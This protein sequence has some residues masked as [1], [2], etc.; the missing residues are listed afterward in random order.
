MTYD[1]YIHRFPHGRWHALAGLMNPAYSERKK[2]VLAYMYVRVHT[3]THTHA[4]TCAHTPTVT[5]LTTGPTLHVQEGWSH[6]WQPAHGAA[7]GLEEGKGSLAQ[8]TD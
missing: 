3:H 4:Y 6:P 7:V 2:H 5:S 1:L 8:A